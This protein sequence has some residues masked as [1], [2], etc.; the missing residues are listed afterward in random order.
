[1]SFEL[2]F[3]SPRLDSPRPDAPVLLAED[4]L[5]IALDIQGVLEN[6]GLDVVGPATRV[7]DAL[8]LLETTR[9]A[10]AVIDC[11]LHGEPTLPLARQLMAREI[12]FVIATAYAPSALPRDVGGVPCLQKPVSEDELL[13]AMR[14]LGVVS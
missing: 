9:V 10:A 5:L 6:A 4:E 7:A 2:A 13:E 11:N 8:T 12:P 1:M 14:S 3:K